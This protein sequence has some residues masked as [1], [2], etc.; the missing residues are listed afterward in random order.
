MEIEKSTTDKSKLILVIAVIIL[1]GALF[2]VM[3]YLLGNKNNN[4]VIKS[5]DQMAKDQGID[6]NKETE[7][8][9]NIEEDVRT[10][11]KDEK[12]NWK[13]YENDKYGFE[14]TLLD[15][16]KGYEVLTESWKGISLDGDSKQYQGPQIIIRNPK[17]SISKPWQDIPIM[18]FTKDEWELIEA[19]NLSVNAAPIGPNKLDENQQ[20]VFALPPRWIGFTDNLGQDEA[21]E[22]SKTIKAISVTTNKDETADW[23]VYENKEF[24]FEIKYPENIEYYPKT[25]GVDFMEKSEAQDKL[26][27]IYLYNELK[28]LPNNE[29]GLSFEDW[30]NKQI[31]NKIFEDGRI[32]KNDTLTGIKVRDQGV[33]PFKNILVKKDNKTYSFVIREDSRF[34]DVFDQI[35]ST[36][37]SVN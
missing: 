32:F 19:K 16:W 26:F 28:Q 9:E 12:E 6:N 3:G 30:I 27:T 17:W 2:G 36:L 14:V 8:D 5:E 37:K 4:T 31:E 35:L 20:Y 23:Q 21:Q 34:M 15:S 24:G 33:V 25:W 10:D 7:K 1:V 11:V 22:I 18:V 29:T 13:I